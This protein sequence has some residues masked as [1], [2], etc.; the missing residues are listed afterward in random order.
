MNDT[1]MTN[2]EPVE[3]LGIKETKEVLIALNEIGLVVY[4]IVK[5][6]VQVYD[7]MKALIEAILSNSDFRQA[8]ADAVDKV[9]D[10]PAEISDI[11]LQEG[12]E[13]IGTQ[14]EYLKKL[15]DV[16]KS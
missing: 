7:D 4:P 8:I 2:E 12:I 1:L 6:G 16:L 5:D 11:D 13:L 10:V 3:K 15:V 14:L 9:M